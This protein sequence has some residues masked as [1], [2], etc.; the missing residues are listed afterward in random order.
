[1]VAGSVVPSACRRL[2]STH[3][4]LGVVPVGCLWVQARLLSPGYPQPSLPSLFPFPWSW[5]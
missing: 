1:M 5:R 2:G 4:S 3:C